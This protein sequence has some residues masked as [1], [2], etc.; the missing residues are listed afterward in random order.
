MLVVVAWNLLVI[1]NRT[2]TPLATAT[3][4]PIVNATGLRQS[5]S[6]FSEP[7]Q[8][9]AWFVFRGRLQSGEVVDLLRGEPIK[10]GDLFPA[11]GQQFANHRWRKL[12][13]RVAQDRNA[14][15]RQPLAEAVFHAWNVRH[16]G[17]Q[18]AVHLELICIQRRVDPNDPAGGFIRSKLASVGRQP[19]AGNFAD[20]VRE[21]ED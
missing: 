17:D 8:F 21:L 4:R 15:Y 19:F 11:F 6:L 13:A 16:S 2:R 10:H 12:H 14:A 18:R 9:D 3:L 7:A 5:W 1:L 20:A